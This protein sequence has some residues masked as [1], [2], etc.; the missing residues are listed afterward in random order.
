MPRSTT[1]L[2]KRR[3]GGPFTPRPTGAAATS[4]PHALDDGFVFWPESLGP[5]PSDG[6]ALV[7][8][9]TASRTLRRPNRPRG[10][11]LAGAVAFC[12]LFFG[13][14]A[15][16]ASAG[17]RV[18]SMLGATKVDAPSSLLAHPAV[19]AAPVGRSLRTPNPT[20]VHQA[21][22]HIA[23]PR[24]KPAAAQHSLQTLRVSP[25]TL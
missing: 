13:G 21:V 22:T 23:V 16:T 6:P 10:R 17:D 5:R 4:E 12:T 19:P 3:L 24:L 1:R 14:A 15:F 18:A 25:A 9:G 8:V 7:R 11:R 2:R 20:Q